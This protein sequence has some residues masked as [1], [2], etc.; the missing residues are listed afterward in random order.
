VISF[1]VNSLN[2]GSKNQIFGTRLG[3]RYRL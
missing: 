1:S 2:I 3:D